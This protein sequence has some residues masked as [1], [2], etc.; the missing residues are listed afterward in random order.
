MTMT[1]VTTMILNGDRVDNYDDGGNDGELAETVDLPNLRAFMDEA[2]TF[3]NHATVTCPCG[4][5]RAS[6]YSRT[7]F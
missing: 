2:V 1:M 6:L 7:S 5:A 4:P 3:T